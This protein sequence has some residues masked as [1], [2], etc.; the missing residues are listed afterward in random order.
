MRRSLL[1]HLQLGLPVTIRHTSMMLP[2]L[3]GGSQSFQGVDDS[4][5]S[6]RLQ[7]DSESESSAWFIAAIVALIVLFY[8][9]CMFQCVKLYILKCCRQ[10]S[11]V[12]NSGA[13]GTVLVHEGRVFNLSED[14]RRAVLE[15]IYAD[16][17]KPATDQDVGQKQKKRKR[18]VFGRESA[19]DNE[20]NEEFPMC[21][22]EIPSLEV[23]ASL[24][25]H[26]AREDDELGII[27]LDDPL[28]VGDSGYCA[29]L[30][31]EFQSGDDVDQEVHRWKKPTASVDC[32]SSSK[33]NSLTNLSVH[34]QL[35][36]DASSTPRT[37][38]CKSIRQLQEL[39]NEASDKID[40]DARI[41]VEPQNGV[42]GGL[43]DRC[44]SMDSWDDN[45]SNTPLP[46]LPL[47]E[48][49]S[50]FHPEKPN[51][52]SGEA[53][54]RKSTNVF[55]MM[56]DDDGGDEDRI[57]Q[58]SDCLSLFPSVPLARHE[59]FTTQASEYT[60]DDDSCTTGDNVW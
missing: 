29:S 41:V 43:P 20:D 38:N 1:A 50:R 16:N 27:S 2:S 8:I 58:S 22:V 4:N 14:Q 48:L 12:A 10:D 21:N 45:E 53:K 39:T 36:I 3:R 60:Y 51:R 37:K 54:E 34:P 7:I 47:P 56:Q 25:T 11:A 40:G 5:L 24:E 15:A 42:E 32:S 55:S 9:I 13:T 33:P 18:K 59:S 44:E 35:T 46:S 49:S 57:R 19:Y 52:L 26:Y 17:S 30:S 23:N 6:R 31:S 28:F